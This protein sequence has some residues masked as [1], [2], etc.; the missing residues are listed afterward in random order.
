MIAYN[1]ENFNMKEPMR[2]R[3]IWNYWRVYTL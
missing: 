3:C 2:V 1:I